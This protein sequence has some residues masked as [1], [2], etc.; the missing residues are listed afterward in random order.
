M[1]TIVGY[2]QFL[3]TPSGWRATLRRISNP[4]SRTISI[5]ALRVEGDAFDALPMEQRSI[6]IHALRVEGDDCKRVPLCY[7]YRN[8]YPRPPGGGRHD[9]VEKALQAGYISIH[10]LRVEGDIRLPPEKG[11]KI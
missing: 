8:F 4:L 7:N 6:S 10:A 9:D 5:H 3:S 1:D 11:K 2:V